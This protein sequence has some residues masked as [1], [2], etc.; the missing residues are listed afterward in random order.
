MRLLKTL[1]FIRAI[2]D[3]SAI[4]IQNKNICRDCK[5]F[6]ANDWDCAKFKDVNIITGKETFESARSVRSDESKCGE[7]GKLFEE[8]QYKIVT[9]PYY[10][11]KEYWKLTPVFG[12]AAFYIYNVLA[13]LHKI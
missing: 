9:V 10:F 1:L 12:F 13:L 6:I 2:V 3:N 8:N 7:Q 11:V 4:R 5:H